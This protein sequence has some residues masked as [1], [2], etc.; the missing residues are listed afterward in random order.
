MNSQHQSTAFSEWDNYFQYRGVAPDFFKSHSLP[1]YLMNALPAEKTAAICDIGCGFGQNLSAI[2]GLG[3]SNVFGIEPSQKAYEHLCALGLKV[4]K[5]EVAQAAALLTE[6]A[7][8]AYITH[9]LEHIPKKEIIPTL[10]LIKQSILA[11]Q[12]KLL[13]AV[14]NAQS[15][16]GAYW[17]YED[18]THE[19]LFT[20][21]SLLH[22]MRA[23]GFENAII[24]D[25]DC[26]M[27]TRSLFKRMVKKTLLSLYEMNYRFWM[28]VTTSAVHRPSPLVFSFEVKAIGSCQ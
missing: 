1:R 12:G 18:W 19:V 9:V 2:R 23:A 13:V 17:R 27:N 24:Y 10:K 22:V 25:A 21:G 20:S 4:F 11:P 16:T 14:P 26:L 5:G 7:K 8:F 6:K 15:F 3:Y 28:R